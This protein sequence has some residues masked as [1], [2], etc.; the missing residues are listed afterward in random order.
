MLE[1]GVDLHMSPLEVSAVM[2]SL[3]WLAMLNRPTFS[4]FHEVY[5]F[6]GPLTKD[7]C[8]VPTEAMSELYTFLALCPLL[9]ADTRRPWQDVLVVTD[10]SQSYGYG[11]SMAPV[12][13]G[14][15]RSIG[16]VAELPNQFVRLKRDNGPSDEPEKPRQG[17]AFTVPLAKSAFRSVIMTRARFK[18]HSST[19]ETGGVALGL[20]WL[21]R[22]P[23]RHSQRSVFLVDAQAVIGAITKGRSSAA[24][25][26][27]DVS[28]VAALCLAG[29]I[30]LRSV[31]VPSEDNPADEP[32]RGHWRAQRLRKSAVRRGKRLVI[33]K[34]KREERA[35]TGRL[36]QVNQ[37]IRR[38]THFG[39]ISSRNKFRR[40]FR[41]CQWS[42]VGSLSSLSH[43]E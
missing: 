30:F 4:A 38:L 8:Q 29:D 9:E 22:S 16:R 1:N 3:T 41:Q 25:I 7:R 19:L 14:I 28:N 20:R 24:R 5:H 31:Y 2:G 18:A 26:R 15:T 37:D 32:S 17:V 21:L 35:E 27:K 10:A 6:T 40:A 33:D 42:D 36:A 12:E 23:A 13:P 34:T 43:E 39:P 11:V